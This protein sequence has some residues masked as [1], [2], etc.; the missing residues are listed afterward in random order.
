[1]AILSERLNCS[2]KRTSCARSASARPMSTFNVV[3]S[4]H[5]GQAVVKALIDRGR[6]EPSKGYRFGLGRNSD[7]GK[8]YLPR[9]VKSADQ[10]TIRC[11]GCSPRGSIPH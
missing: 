4:G 3:F 7:S 6:M 1:M 11:Q 8:A 9:R 10:K 2:T 5:N